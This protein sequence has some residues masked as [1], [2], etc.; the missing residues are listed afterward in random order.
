MLISKSG[1][2][3]LERELGKLCR[4]KAVQYSSSTDRTKYDPVIT[5]DDVEGILGVARYELE[6]R[7]EYLRPGVVT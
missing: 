4:T 3:S 2:R 5:P 7:E 6:V 1:V